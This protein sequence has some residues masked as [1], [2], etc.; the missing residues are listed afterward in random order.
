MPG[1]E[2]WQSGRGRQFFEAQ[3]PAGLAA[4]EKIAE[5]LPAVVTALDKLTRPPVPFGYRRRGERWID[6][7]LDRQSYEAAFSGQVQADRFYA[8]L[9][10]VVPA[11]DRGR[12]EA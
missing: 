5:T 6:V 2:F 11:G 3:L 12:V 1:P 4:L 9:Q 7:D 10:A 8:A